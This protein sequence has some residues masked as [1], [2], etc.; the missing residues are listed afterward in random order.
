MTSLSTTQTAAVSSKAERPLESSTLLLRIRD[1]DGAVQA[2]IPNLPG[3]EAELA[4]VK[5]LE[6]PAGR[7]N[8]NALEALPSAQRA[9]LQGDGPLA[10]CLYDPQRAQQLRLEW[11]T[12]PRP[13]LL[14]RLARR[15][16]S[17]EDITCFFDLL[18]RGELRTAEPV[19]GEW[20]PQ[21]YVVEGILN[22]FTV[23][24]LRTMEHGGWDKIPLKT[25]EYTA[26]DFA[27]EGVRY[28]P[29]A[30]VRKGAY[31]GA[32]TVIMPHVFVNTGAYVAGEG[33]MLD[34]AARVASAAQL[35]RGVKLGAG[36]GLEGVLE[37]AGRLPTIVED[38]VKIGAMCEVAGII[39]EGAVLASGVVMASG[40]RIY[41]EESGRIL[42]PLEV[43][44]GDKTYLVPEI[45]SYR[46]AVGG[47]LMHPAGKSA[48]SAILLKPGDLRER[49]TLQNFVRQG[50]LYD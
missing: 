33:V 3:H 49:N 46:L 34:G 16:G 24:E 41:D 36:S 50:L 42:A 37:P 40:K 43:R 1:A 45:P 30:I 2:L 14:A 13:G 25:S 28:V 11:S 20:L 4:L 17:V 10:R 12:T 38:H 27:R 15:E 23:L 44:V 35:G 18:E 7:W 39:R 48:T 29:G 5:R 32:G 21:P 6:H 19:G 31:L 47:A 8:L 9:L 22:A 26:A